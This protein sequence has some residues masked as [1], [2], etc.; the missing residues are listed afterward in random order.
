[1]F[2][3][4]DKVGGND[5]DVG[6]HERGEYREGMNDVGLY[7]KGG[8]VREPFCDTKTFPGDLI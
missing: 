3:K 8:K 2:S 5:L 7:S 4:R 1:M 6:E